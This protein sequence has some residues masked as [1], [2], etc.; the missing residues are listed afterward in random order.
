MNN[1]VSIIIPCYDQAQFLNQALKSVYEQTY[2]MWECIIVNDGSNDNTQGIAK[3]WEEKD[4]RFKYVYQENKGLSGARNT[5]LEIA[6]G[7]FI[8]FLDADDFIEKNKLNTSLKKIE[9]HYDLDMVISNF[10]LYNNDNKAFFPPY[11]I[12]NQGQLNFKTILMEWDKS[13]TIPIHCGFF[14]RNLFHEFRFPEH[15]KAKEDWL[16]WVYIF[17]NGAKAEYINQKLA[18]YRIHENS[19]TQSKFMKDDFIKAYI[20]LED[21]IS[22]EDYKEYTLN[23]ISRL[24]DSQ[25]LLKEELKEIKKYKIFRLKYFIDKVMRRLNLKSNK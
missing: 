11:C 15:I 1:L 12:L 21:I 6:S 5:G 10:N 4:A 19:M 20:Y 13:F 7:E 2:S 23:L 25:S 14:K 8:Q 22:K 16:M 3:L 9:N 18:F 17:N 24:Y